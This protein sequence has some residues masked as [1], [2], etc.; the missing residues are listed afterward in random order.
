MN[1]KVRARLLA[2]SMLLIPVLG[3]GEDNS[4]T[5]VLIQRLLANDNGESQYA[6]EEARHLPKKD[7]AD[8]VA[9]LSPYMASDDPDQRRRV[10]QLVEVLSPPPDDN[11]SAYANGLYHPPQ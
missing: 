5:Q 3:L 1:T 2:G 4:Y 8:L 10:G 6:L 7:K 9:Q 11:I